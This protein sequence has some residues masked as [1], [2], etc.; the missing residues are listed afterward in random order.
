MSCEYFERCIEPYLDQALEVKEGLD[1][2][3]HL[4]ACSSCAD[5]LEAERSF[6]KFV[7]QSITVPSLDEVKKQR[8]VSRAVCGV[9]EKM[10]DRQ[11]RPAF[12]LR[13]FGIGLVTAA[14]LLL[15]VFKLFFSVTSGDDMMQKFARDASMTYGIYMT[16]Q[17]PP[18]FANADDKMVTR[19]LNSRMGFRLKM[20]CITDAATK[21]LGGRL[22][23]LLDRKSATMI[24]ERNGAN[25][26]LFAFKGGHLA[27]PEKYK[28]KVPDL[29]LYI[30]MISG[31]PV[32]M[33]NHAGMTYSM[34]GDINPDDLVQVAKTIDYR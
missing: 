14:A 18:E 25:L 4:H 23:R 16:E 20:P 15:F 21:L 26:L 30:R 29:N 19:W 28:V 32:A 24:Y 33:W 22:C 27:M 9:E 12:Q 31:R 11:R 17:V 2:E 10:A 6:R 13:D 3:Q 5:L 7:R 34:V 8:I 1:V